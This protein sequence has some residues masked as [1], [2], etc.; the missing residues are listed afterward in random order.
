MP[1]LSQSLSLVPANSRLIESGKHR[2]R[3]F[4]GRAPQA[5]SSTALPTERSSEHLAQGTAMNGSLVA[6]LTAASAPTDVDVVLAAAKLTS[7]FMSNLAGGSH[8]GCLLPESYMSPV[9]HRMPLLALKIMIAQDESVARFF[10]KPLQLGHHW[11]QPS[12]SMLVAFCSRPS[13]DLPGSSRLCNHGF[14]FVWLLLRRWVPSV[15][16]WLFA[17]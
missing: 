1:I 3:K 14:R 17:M 4:S 15:F 11:S 7:Q 13:Q 2:T 16:A 10:C 12:Q 8:W 9:L 5:P 6:E